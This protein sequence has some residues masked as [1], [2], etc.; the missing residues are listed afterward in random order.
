MKKYVIAITVIT[1]V[2]IAFT[3]ASCGGNQTPVPEGQDVYGR[4]L[5][6]IYDIDS[7]PSGEFRAAYEIGDTSFMGQTMISANCADYVLIKK[8]GDGYALT[9]LFKKGVLSAVGK[10]TGDDFEEGVVSEEGDWQAVTF[11]VQRAE[12]DEKIVLRCTVKAM[13]R[14]VNYSVKLD[15]KNTILVG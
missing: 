11:D 12:L 14:T 3:L 8:S 4:T 2:V 6:E 5:G 10:L 1:V 13:N 15:M 9:C 7:Q